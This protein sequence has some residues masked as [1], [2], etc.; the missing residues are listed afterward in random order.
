MQKISI[1]QL[2]FINLSLLLLLGG[3]VGYKS[4]F[5]KN[6]VVYAD[7]VKLFDGFQMTKEMKRV[8]EKE[9]NARKLIVDSLYAETQRADVSE[10]EKARLVQQFVQNRDQL[11]QFGQQFASEEAAKIWSRIKSYTETFAA[12]NGYELIVGS[13]ERKTVLYADESV[14][15]TPELI[16]Y[17]N[18]KYEGLK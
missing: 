10:A 13:D 16:H 17:I 2:F 15:I 8:G 5:K 18:T 11:E 9:F 7:N 1:K 4:F 3:F 12:E 6:S 14:D